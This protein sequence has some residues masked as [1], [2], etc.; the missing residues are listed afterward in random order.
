MKSER[1]IPGYE[2]KKKELNENI[3]LKVVVFRHGPKLS[4][5][6]EKNERAAYFDE[7][8]K[9]GYASADIP[10]QP[11]NYHI[12]TSPV[13]RA[14]VTADII[15]EEARQSESMPF[16]T[17]DEVLKRKA[18][19]V[20]Y[21]KPGEAEN[22]AYV[23]DFATL[24][25]IQ[26]ELES[27]VRKEV[28]RDMP[29]VSEIDREAEVRNRIDSRILTIQFAENR[30]KDPNARQFEMS[31]ERLADRFALRVFGFAK[32]FSLLESKNE[33][34]TDST[35]GEYLNLD[36]SHS[37]P[38]MSFLKKYLVF[39]DGTRAY[40]LTGEEFFERVGGII[41]ESGHFTLDLR[42]VN[43]HVTIGIEGNFHGKVFQGT[44]EDPGV[45]S[46]TV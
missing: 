41:P 13:E 6:G 9:E 16:L 14:I 31:Y 15:K 29:E 28:S 43:E 39:E 23:R 2:E 8:V 46:K 26:K 4:A 45:T 22:D 35:K 19:G 3:T 36:V 18:L 30:E 40:D 44:I 7:S 25:R 33:A 20:P 10:E 34:R 27:G 32:H 1:G 37:F 12:N 38:V 24:V 42:R 21:G 5:S 17:K 11:I